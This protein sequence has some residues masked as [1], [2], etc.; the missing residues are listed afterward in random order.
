MLYTYIDEIVVIVTRVKQTIKID[1]N[2]AIFGLVYAIKIK[3]IVL[4][5]V[6]MK[7]TSFVSMSVL[8][9]TIIVVG[10]VVK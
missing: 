5:T 9:H 4:L 1:C 8:Q 2:A 7:Q 3:I 6:D 10:V